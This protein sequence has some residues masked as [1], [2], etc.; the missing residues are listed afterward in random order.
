MR[1][2]SKLGMINRYLYVFILVYTQK[3]TRH[4][5]RDLWTFP[6]YLICYKQAFICRNYSKI[7]E[8]SM[9]NSIG[10]LFKMKEQADQAHRALQVA[11][12]KG[13]EITL[14]VHKKAVPLNAEHRVSV[15][16]IGISA[17]IGAVI[18]VIITA[19]IGFLISRSEIFVPGFWPNFSRGPYLEMMAFALFLATGALVGAI[20]GAAIRLLTSRE[21]ARITPTGIKRGGILV[22]VNTDRAQEVLAKRV[23]K[24]NGALDLEN[25]TEKWDA[26]VWE[27][28][29]KLE[30]SVGN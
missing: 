18:A 7:T 12:F 3:Y 19:I 26:N 21:N 13:E 30:P 23:L 5:Y 10:G 29:R 20:L 25:L 17:V 1:I 6:R 16:E 28:F 11:G 14:W 27:G 4:L 2:G 24:E 22:V 15:K 8:G 9:E